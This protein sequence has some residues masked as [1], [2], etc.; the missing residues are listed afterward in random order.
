MILK[1]F[2]HWRLRHI[3]RR[4]PIERDIW[5]DLMVNVTLFNGLSSVQK[6]RLRV[7]T[8]RFLHQKNIKP[9][10]GYELDRYIMVS[11]SA[12]ACLLILELGL[13]YYQGWRDIIVYPSPFIVKRNEVDALGIVSYQSRV[14]GGEAW[15]RGPVILD[16]QAVRDEMHQTSAR[17]NVVLHEFAH[18]IDMLNGR[19]N[20]M[21]PLHSRMKRKDW[22]QALSEAFAELQ[23]Q[24]ETGV[25]R[26]NPYAATDPAEFFAV[27][28]E[29]FFTNP[30]QLKQHFSA[31]YKQLVLF[32]RQD[33]SLR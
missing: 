2:R 1:W 13:D 23:I 29:T 19:A 11:L 5:R 14:L 8:T 7:L 17:Q 9:S 18:K 16:G 33:P 4:Y 6:A 22:T 3:L 31:V 28:T 21:P 27:A 15:L 30:H 32:Y 20:G 10:P 12:Q 25:A 24:V 26:I